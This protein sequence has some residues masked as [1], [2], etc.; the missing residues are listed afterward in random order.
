MLWCDIVRGLIDDGV[1]RFV[2]VGPGKVLRGLLRLIHP[3]PRAYQVF[4]AGDQRSIARV[5]E[6]LG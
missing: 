2:E 5:V 6:S 1:D 3:D 4:T